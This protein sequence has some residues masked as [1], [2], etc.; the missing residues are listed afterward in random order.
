MDKR[1]QTSGVNLELERKYNLL[2]GRN[3]NDRSKR[4]EL[5]WKWLSNLSNLKNENTASFS[6]I[7]SL[8]G[9]DFSF[10]INERI[11]PTVYLDTDHDEL[12]FGGFQ[13]GVRKR[14]ADLMLSFKTEHMRTTKIQQKVGFKLGVDNWKVIW[15]LT[16]EDLVQRAIDSNT[17][18][19]EIRQ[20]A[21]T[22]DKFLTEDQ[23]NGQRAR[24]KPVIGT[25][26]HRYEIQFLTDNSEICYLAL[27][28][29]SAPMNK[30]DTDISSST[31]LW[32]QIEI[33]TKIDHPRFSTKGLLEKFEPAFA[34]AIQQYLTKCFQKSGWYTGMFPLDYNTRVRSRIDETLFSRIIIKESRSKYQ[35]IREHLMQD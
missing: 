6:S 31:F 26:V 28:S 9:G 18:K 11:R 1:E 35:I 30:E 2:L 3:R 21:L 19:S 16:G 27:D 17:E 4:F 10:N 5:I 25:L 23:L 14:D 32:H 12:F 34:S 8:L 7:K 24:F 22:M 15:S 13:F 20:A 33:K 29:V